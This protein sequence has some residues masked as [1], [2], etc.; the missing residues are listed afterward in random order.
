MKASIIILSLPDYAD[1]FSRD[2]YEWYRHFWCSSLKLRLF[3]AFDRLQT[4]NW[5]LFLIV[6]V[7]FNFFRPCK[8]NFRPA[9][10]ANTRTATW[11]NTFLR[12]ERRQPWDWRSSGHIDKLEIEIENKYRKGKKIVK[13]RRKNNTFGRMVDKGRTVLRVCSTFLST[14][15]KDK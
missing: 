6:I 15:M 2:S 13:Y 4:G 1:L 12:F 14:E 5:E 3:C 9:L 10:F 11:I 7:S 8:G